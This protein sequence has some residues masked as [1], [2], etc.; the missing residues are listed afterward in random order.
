LCFALESER[1][2]KGNAWE[3]LGFGVSVGQQIGRYKKSW[4][5][6]LQGG[7]MMIKTVLSGRLSAPAQRP[8]L[9]L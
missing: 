6:G 7:W 4:S 9:S 5:L 3:L 8:I 2:R 1:D